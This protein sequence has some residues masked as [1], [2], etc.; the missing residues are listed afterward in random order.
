MKRFS[1]QYI[2]TGTG[3]TLKRGVITTDNHGTVT[4]I[5]DTGGSLRESAHTPFY[6]GIII[7]GF[8]NCHCHIELSSMKGAIPRSTLLP[9]FI[10]HIR[11]QRDKFAAEAMRAA[12]EA[13]RD[14]YDSGIN[15]CA[16]IC[17]NSLS[18]EVKE[19]SKI[20]Y[21][22]LLEIFGTDPEGAERRIADITSL[23]AEAANYSAPWYITPHSLYSLS[24]PLLKKVKDLTTDNRITSI[25]FMESAAEK[26][27]LKSGTGALADSY[28]SIGITREMMEQRARDHAEAILSLVTLSGNLLLVH[29]TRAEE[30]DIEKVMQ[31]DNIWWCLCPLSN[32]YIEEAEP[33][34][35]KLRQYGAGIVLGTDSLASNTTLSILEEMKAIAASNPSIPLTELIQWATTNGARA[36]GLS[37]K[38][39]SIEEGKKPGLLLLENIDLEKPHLHNSVTVRRLL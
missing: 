31:R 20:E 32:R 38:L 10:R 27:M 18:F 33:P 21:I 19:K 39:G 11:E 5:T 30:S 15:A 3:T 36:L 13:D 35:Q 22:N 37:S 6:N 1:A 7:P 4:G 16:D 26:E 34:V 29:N 28:I 9:G 25:H 14:M 23:A 24:V 8:V 2:I 17:N 12:V